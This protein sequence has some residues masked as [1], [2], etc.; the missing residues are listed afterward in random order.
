MPTRATLRVVGQSDDEAMTVLFNPAS[1]KVS[2]TNKLQ[3]EESGSSGTGGGQLRQATRVTT[4][5]LET[6]LVFDK[7][8]ERPRRARLYL[9]RQVSRHRVGGRSSASTQRRAISSLPV[10]VSP[11]TRTVASDSD[12]RLS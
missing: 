7:P 1:L 3:D 12:S 4:T 9:L 5:K 6:E 10:P 11:D 8:A 2:L